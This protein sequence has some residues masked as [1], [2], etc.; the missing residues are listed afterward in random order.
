MTNIIIENVPKEVVKRFWTKVSF[1]SINISKK[2]SYKKD[3]TVKLYKE[4]NDPENISY[5]PFDNA[6]D[7]INHLHSNNEN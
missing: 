1:S 5:G 7:F 4:V 2:R 6:L 3:I